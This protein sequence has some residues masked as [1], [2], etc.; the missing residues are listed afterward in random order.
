[1]DHQIICASLFPTRGVLPDFF[2]LFSFPCSADHK[3][4]G[5]GPRVIKSFFGLATNT[6]NG[7]TTCM[8]AINVSVE[9]NDGGFLPGIILLTQ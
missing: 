6:L 5:I 4:S 2:F 8:M 9:H 7:E 3:L 1:M